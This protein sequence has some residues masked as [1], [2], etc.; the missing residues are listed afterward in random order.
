MWLCYSSKGGITYNEA[1]NMPIVYRKFNVKWVSDRIKEYN[2]EVEKANNKGTSLD[3][4]DLAKKKA[5][6]PDFVT[7]RTAAKK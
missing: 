5:D 3:M 6:L 1:Y 4:D 2:K 7:S